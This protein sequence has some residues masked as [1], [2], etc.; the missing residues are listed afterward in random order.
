MERLFGE[1]RRGTVGPVRF[2]WLVSTPEEGA[3]VSV[4]F[5]VPKKSFKRA[6][7]RNLI[8]R[9]MRESFRT[10]KHA[11]VAAAT[12]AGR[13]IDI[14]LICSPPVAKGAAA[15]AKGDAKAAKADA[16]AAKTSKR[17]PVPIPIPDFKTLDHAIEKILAK[18]LE[19][20]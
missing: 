19:R 15:T 9:R 16:R 12:A 8:K 5:S 20:S 1:G 17:A 10:R 4:L 3:A 2:C 11:L 18:I 7:K 14:A 6:W 13:H